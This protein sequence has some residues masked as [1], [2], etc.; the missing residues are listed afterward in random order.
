MFPFCENIVVTQQSL[1]GQ[2]SFL[3]KASSFDMFCKTI[4]KW[5]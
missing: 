4:S 5:I 2:K 1:K 3:I